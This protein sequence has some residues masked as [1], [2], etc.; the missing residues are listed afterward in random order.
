LRF[1]HWRFRLSVPEGLAGD[2]RRAALERAVTRWYQARATER[3]TARVNRWA[4][5][6]GY[7]PT[8]TLVRSQRQRWGSC[9]ADGT[10]RFN[11]RIIM[12]P[13]ALIDYVVVHELVHLR[14]RNHSAEFWAGVRDLLP[15]YRLRR[16]LLREVGPGLTL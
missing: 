8:A 15:D 4:A 16:A 1:D 2:A 10:L 7:A 5:I 3:L 6:A 11:W 12:A 14:T 13:P 9:G